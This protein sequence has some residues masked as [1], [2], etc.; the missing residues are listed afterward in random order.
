V[1][2]C[3]SCGAAVTD[4]SFCGAC[5]NRVAGEPRPLP[6]VR[7]TLQAPTLPPRVP[8]P[9]AGGPDQ[10]LERRRSLYWLLGTV[11]VILLL[12]VA[13]VFVSRLPQEQ[14]RS[15]DQEPKAVNQ[16]TQPKTSKKPPTFATSGA[17]PVTYQGLF[18]GMTVA[19][20]LATRPQLE[21]IDGGKSDPGARDLVLKDS[22]ESRSRSN[23]PW[24]E[25]WIK[26][27]GIYDI[28]INMSEISPAD[29]KAFEDHALTFLGDPNVTYA[30]PVFGKVSHVWIDGDVRLRFDSRRQEKG[31]VGRWLYSQLSPSHVSLT[32]A[33][34]PISLE[35]FE[36]SFS[37]AMSED[38]LRRLSVAIFRQE[39]GDHSADLTPTNPAPAL[40]RAP[41]QINGVRLGMTAQEVR[42][43][44]GAQG[45]FMEIHTID[46]DYSQGSLTFSDNREHFNV[47]FLHGELAF[48]SYDRSQV[49]KQLWI[50]E[51]TTL[52]DRYGTPTS[53]FDCCAG[54][55]IV[56]SWV[57]NQ[58]EA[59]FQLSFPDK[60]TDR[61][62][63]L[64]QLM[65]I[66]MVREHQE[67]EHT[68]TPPTYKQTDSLKSFF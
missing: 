47:A 40:P 49:D 68:R 33:V 34:Y 44:L 65:D 61:G 66:S 3:S 64:W 8:H 46:Q 56:G 11:A 25:V 43:A 67:S 37:S 58:T 24:V 10:S 63:I 59:Q 36:T 16:T 52:M 38:P 7:P 41:R 15:R 48:V 45:A 57:D 2:F 26:D 39:W 27:G 1:G 23:A 50:P 55:P 62:F 60:G 9:E 29:A 14:L 30:E 51:L 53:W 31:T 35:R 54:M 12:V 17:L 20:A 22:F 18:L 32:M 4:G 21:P 6:S 5:G 28:E 13:S 42:K 19:Q